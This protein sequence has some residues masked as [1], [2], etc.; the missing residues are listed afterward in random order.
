MKTL[1]FGDE[2]GLRI[3]KAALPADSVCGVV[4]AEGR[5]A[6][7]PVARQW[8]ES[9]SVP[10]MVQPQRKN[11]PRFESFKNDVKRL[12]PELSIVCSY[13][14]ILAEDI[15]NI[16]K[17]GTFNVHAGLLPEYR[18]ANVLNWVIINGEKE[19]GVTIH[20]ITKGVD[21]GPIVARKKVL[22]E[23]EDTALTLR[24]RL[25]DATVALI[26]ESWKLLCMDHISTTPQD[27]SK[28][29]KWQRRKP[30]DGLIDWG[31][32]VEE[33]Y[34]LIR[35]LVAPWPGAYY[36]DSNGGK[37]VIDRFLSL[38]EVEALKN[39]QAKNVV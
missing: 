26:T 8:A 12:V 30:E 27:E 36:Y 37:V 35:A 25:K 3:L 32:P 34:N 4:A 24:E 18:G 31:R 6:A 9:L 15:F 38:K 7:Q 28:A 21:E 13:S 39:E 33:I 14:L 10:Y 1:C 23:E 19:T 16:P 2:I 22:I 5:V 20:R 11:N 29:K 17:K